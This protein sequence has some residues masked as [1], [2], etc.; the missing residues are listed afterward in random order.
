MPLA[1]KNR[2][3]GGGAGAVGLTV[4]Q[5]MAGGSGA[6]GG[7]LVASIGAGGP[8]RVGLASGVAPTA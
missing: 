4:G 2:L 1:P 5:T 8:G 6:G 7:G 3:R